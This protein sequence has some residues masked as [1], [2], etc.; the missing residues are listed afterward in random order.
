MTAL[1]NDHGRRPRCEV[2]NV[3]N[4]DIVV[5]KFELQ[6]GHYVYIQTNALKKGINSLISLLCFSTT[7]T[8]D[9]P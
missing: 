3:L 1:T 5:S 8:L 7:M 2:S 6:S 4:S 9:N